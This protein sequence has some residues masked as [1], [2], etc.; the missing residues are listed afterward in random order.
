MPLGSTVLL[1]HSMT[2]NLAAFVP[3]ARRSLTTSIIL[4]SIHHTQD[5]CIVYVTL[6]QRLLC[7]IRPKG[8]RASAYAARLTSLPDE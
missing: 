6:M 1:G 7:Q 4:S 5:T 8:W 3:L 2:S